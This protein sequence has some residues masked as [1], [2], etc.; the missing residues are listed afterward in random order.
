MNEFNKQ[1]KNLHL[2]KLSLYE[3][4]K[5][6][7]KKVIK[8]VIS[9]ISFNVKLSRLNLFLYETCLLTYIHSHYL[10]YL[11]VYEQI[12]YFYVI[13]YSFLMEHTIYA[14]VMRFLSYLDSCHRS[15]QKQPLRRFFFLL[16]QVHKTVKTIW[17]TRKRKGFFPLK[18]IPKK[19]FPL[20]RRFT[21]SQYAE[22]DLNKKSSSKEE[23]ARG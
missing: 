19:A 9:H 2:I 15:S 23:T 16:S 10:S 4:R 3:R 22:L 14:E 8:N 17:R 13:L 1:R 5:Q 20:K 18:P 12:H 11:P 6:T 21:A 7:F